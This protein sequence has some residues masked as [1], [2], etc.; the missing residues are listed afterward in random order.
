[1]V[2]YELSKNLHALGANVTFVLPKKLP[3]SYNFMDLKF[4]D[5][6]PFDSSTKPLN[7]YISPSGY[8]KEISNLPKG[9][10]A[11]GLT[12]EVLQYAA[13]MKKLL[14]NQSFD[15]IHAHDW[16]T[17]PAGIAAKKILKKPLVLH[18]HSTEFDRCANGPISQTIYNIEKKGFDFADRIICISQFTKNKVVRNYNIRPDKISIVYNA[19]SGMDTTPKQVTAFKKAG[20]KVVLFVGRITIQKGLDYFVKAAGKVITKLPNTV[21][22]IAGSGDME[23]QILNEV[24]TLGLADKFIFAGFQRNDNL[25]A[26][27]QSADLCVMPSVSEPFGLVALEA[28]V[29][30]T[31]TIIS[32]QSGVSEIINHALKVDFWDIDEMANKIVCTLQH[33]VLSQLIADYSVLEAKSITWLKS[34]AQL[35]QVYQ[36]LF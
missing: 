13:S 12:G 11:E 22:V 18:V 24:A 32:N 25:I 8:R 4:A 17:Y 27:Y 35:A 26:L 7:P 30:H 9:V 5:S 20:K 29:N 3:L 19:I 16:L 10:Y 15:I 6:R 36:A 31:P 28:M 21:F 34:T 2:C 23:Q 33:P 1:V 14:K